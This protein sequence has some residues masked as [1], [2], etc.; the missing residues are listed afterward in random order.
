LSF[1]W[2][3]IIPINS[4]LIIAFH[5]DNYTGR[6]KLSFSVMVVLPMYNTDRDTE[7]LSVEA[8]AVA[9]LK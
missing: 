6:G 3:Q 9:E 8:I 7:E 2:W 4:L 5:G 1:Y